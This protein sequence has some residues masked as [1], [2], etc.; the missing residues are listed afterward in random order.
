M[1]I[2]LILRKASSQ[3]SLTQTLIMPE[4]TAYTE[5]KFRYEKGAQ[6]GYENKAFYL[7]QYTQDMAIEEL[8]NSLG[9]RN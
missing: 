2:D 4:T 7:L 1:T 9:A 6:G 5:N 3:G 8:I